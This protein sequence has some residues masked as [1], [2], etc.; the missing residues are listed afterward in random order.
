MYNAIHALKSVLFD[1]KFTLKPTKRILCVWRGF[2]APHI[3]PNGG[4]K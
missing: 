4:T 2:S 3:N 1:E